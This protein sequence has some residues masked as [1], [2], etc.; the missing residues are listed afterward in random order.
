[1]MHDSMPTSLV[2][3]RFIMH[4]KEAPEWAEVHRN[5]APLLRLARIGVNFTK[6]LHSGDDELS[7]GSS[8]VTTAEHD[9][10]LRLNTPVLVDLPPPP[11]QEEMEEYHSF[12][13]GQRWQAEVEKQYVDLAYREYCKRKGVEQKWQKGVEEMAEE[14]AALQR[15]ELPLHVRNALACIEEQE[16]LERAGVVE[17]YDGFLTWVDETVPKWLEAVTQREEERRQKEAARKAA[18]EA[19]KEALTKELAEGRQLPAVP[20][21]SVVAGSSSMSSPG[22]MVY[23]PLTPQPQPSVAELT[24]SELR[25]K[26]I[27]M[28]EQ[29]EAAMKRRQEEL[30]AQ[31]REKESELRDKIEAREKQ[32]LEAEAQQRDEELARKYEDLLNQET[33]LQSR[34]N[35]R[36]QERQQQDEERRMML[37][38]IA[39][40]EQLL[41]QRLRDQEDKRKALEE[42]KARQAALHKA[43]YYEHVRAEEEL[44]RRRLQEREAARAEEEHRKA[45]EAEE[46]R[47]RQAEQLQREQAELE[48]KLAQRQQI[49]AIQ[50]QQEEALRRAQEEHERAE[51]ERQL[52]FLREQE[53]QVKARVRA[54][55]LAELQATEQRRSEERRQQLAQL[56]SWATS[57]GA[58]HGYG[59]YPP[60]ST[61]YPAP[62]PPF[63]PPQPTLPTA[64]YAVAAPP[65]LSYDPRY[66]IPSQAA[67]VAMMAP[68]VTPTPVPLVPAYATAPYA[69]ALAPPPPSAPYGWPAT[70]MYA[71]APQQYY[72][73]R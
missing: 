47:R 70:T 43:E 51:K 36:T 69:P 11:S 17:S 48:A 45:A 59:S 56:Q 65:V 68:T 33:E 39:A 49:E 67:P 58:S 3:N 57:A 72:A 31:L 50:R 54:Q 71:P 13:L 8:P 52:R 55:E 40:E 15:R 73:P 44:L 66:T 25:R 23:E 64:S 4:V 29:E 60:V 18:M 27:K 5:Y 24:P 34:I 62:Q 32:R 26:A 63:A 1:M 22:D 16:E 6:P 7:P 14:L 21:A 10:L 38:H 12:V 46:A 37:E 61:T 9:Q 30:A 35:A 53:E 2:G 41:R 28:L 42:E 20:A 19:A